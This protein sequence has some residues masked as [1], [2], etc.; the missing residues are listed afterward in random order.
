[1]EES[2]YSSRVLE[3]MKNLNLL[4]IVYLSVII[5]IAVDMEIIDINIIS[6]KLVVANRKVGSII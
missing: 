2:R 1:M 5:V 3:V 6:R 4:A